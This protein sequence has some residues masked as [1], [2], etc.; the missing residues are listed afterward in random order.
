MKTTLLIALAS[1]ALVTPAVAQDNA[2]FVG[3]RAELAA[4]VAEVDRFNANDVAYSATLGVDAPFD[5]RWTIGAETTV[6]NVF[7]NHREWGVAG[8][9]GYALSP[10]TLVFGRVGYAR[11]DDA[12]D[13]T[14]E[15]LALG[16][17]VE[18]RLSE[19]T[20]INAQYRYTDFDQGDGAHG[21]LI[22][23]GYR[24]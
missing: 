6:S 8:R 24:F 22:G 7:E 13:L 2:G 15:G 5:D 11:F 16:A 19:R 10:N 4:G 1:I 18:H 14:R 21:A 12:R 17:G 20:F 3:V 23:F 9:L